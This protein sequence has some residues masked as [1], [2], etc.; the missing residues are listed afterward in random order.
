MRQTFVDE[1]VANTVHDI[2]TTDFTK[3]RTAYTIEITGSFNDYT[4][5]E[6]VVSS[7]GGKATVLEWND[8][9]EIMY[10]S[11]WTGNKFEPTQTSTDS[12][13][14]NVPPFKLNIPGA[15]SLGCKFP[16][17][18]TRICISLI[19][20]PINTPFL[21]SSTKTVTTQTCV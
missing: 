15:S 7:N 20:E 17:F 4:I 10:V 11:A 6:T 5:G 16:Q 2:L 12:V 14:N 8:D 3:T 1:M 9:D 13:S 18:N 19:V 21:Y